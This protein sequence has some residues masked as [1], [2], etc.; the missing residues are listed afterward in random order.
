MIA[1]TAFCSISD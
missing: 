1:V